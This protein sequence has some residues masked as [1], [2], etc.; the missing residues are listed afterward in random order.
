MTCQE[1]W[2]SMPELAGKVSAE[3]SAHAQRC[4]A[5]ALALDNQRMLAAGLRVVAV[6]WGRGKAPGR[7]EAKLLAEFRGQ[8]G[9]AARPAARRWWI[10]AAAWA[11]AAAVVAAAAVLLFGTWQ[12]QP[13]VP[14]SP[15]VTAEMASVDWTAELP[16]EAASADSGGE[17]IPLPNADRLP[18]DERVNLVRVELPRSAM[19]A[20]GYA[21]TA[22]R[23]DER[24]QADVVLGSDGLARAVRFVNE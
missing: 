1:F 16:G 15:A 4:T 2:D 12:R 7:V 13:I 9:L 19:I 22:D 8:A 17:F 23:A 24:V 5:C 6:E 10:P 14:R 11:T 21:V 3:V 18:P 20:L